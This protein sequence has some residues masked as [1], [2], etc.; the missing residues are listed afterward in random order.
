M[1]IIRSQN[2]AGTDHN[3]YIGDRARNN[4][5]EGNG[6]QAHEEHA[7]KKEG[8]HRKRNVI[9]TF[10]LRTRRFNAACRAANALTK[11]KNGTLIWDSPHILLFIYAN[12]SPEISDG[13]LTLL[14]I[15]RSR[16][17]TGEVRRNASP[18]LGVNNRGIVTI[19]EAKIVVEEKT[20]LDAGSVEGPIGGF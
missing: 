20:L 1:S 10:D 17:P 15:R 5:D 19:A 9:G 2:S 18:R 4:C 11:I 3:T 16:N 7:V 13:I 6:Q 8:E 12:A 14:S